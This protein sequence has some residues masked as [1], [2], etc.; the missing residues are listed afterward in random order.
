MIDFEGVV[1][2][3]NPNGYIGGWFGSPV[4]F[5]E[6]VGST[7]DVNVVN[8]TLVTTTT[9]TAR[10]AAVAFDP[11]A[12]YGAGDYVVTFDSTLVISDTNNNGTV[13]IWSGDGYDLT[14]SSPNALI[15]D[16]LSGTVD[17][18]GTATSTELANYSF[19]TNQAQQSIAFTYDGSSALVLFFG[20]ATDGYPFPE[21]HYDNI[22]IQLVIPEPNSFMLPLAAIFMAFA[23]RRR[24]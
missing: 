12:L 2:S 21:I 8:D 14:E 19:T 24:R 5:G 16:T 15:V 10:Y 6:W 7:T 11:G 4:A 3:D 22:E 23:T 9:S 17:T 20:A 18:Q 1:V 13:T